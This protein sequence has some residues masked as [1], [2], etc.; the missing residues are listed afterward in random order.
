MR[1][2]TDRIVLDAA[3]WFQCGLNH[4]V[5]GRQLAFLH[6]RLGELLA[7]VDWSAEFAR[8]PE[9]RSRASPDP[10]GAGP[11][12]PAA[13]PAGIPPLPVFAATRANICHQCDRHDTCGVWALRTRRALLGNSCCKNMMQAYLR[14]PGSACLGDRPPRWGPDVAALE[15]AQRKSAQEAP[16]ERPGPPADP[17]A[18]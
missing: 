6:R 4:Q 10:V 13:S 15:D 1:N 12:P 9:A 5:T 3:H 2:I 18:A 8:S 14:K 7:A 17:E 11:Q 16:N